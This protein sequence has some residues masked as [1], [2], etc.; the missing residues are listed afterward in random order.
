MVL[1]IL[2]GISLT[3]VALG[4]AAMF[5]AATATKQLTD[6]NSKAMNKLGQ[7][8]FTMLAGLLGVAT[9]LGLF[10]LTMHA[11]NIG[12]GEIGYAT[13]FLGGLTA[14]IVGLGMA[15]S[16]VANNQ[17][18]NLLSDEKYANMFKSIGI[19][20]ASVLIAA[21]S[22]SLINMTSAGGWSTLQNVVP[23]ILTLG[24]V[25]GAVAGILGI[26]N[27]KLIN[28]NSL[29]KLPAMLISVAVVTGAM[30][31][32][33]GAIVLLNRFAPENI[34]ESFG[35]LAALAGLLLGMTALF[36][37]ISMIPFNPLQLSALITNMIPPVILVGALAGVVILLKFHSIQLK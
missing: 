30:L 27:T 37:V 29:S 21:A 3:V 24:A 7:V 20:I 31:V 32:L 18:V 9:V 13:A 26:A 17:K 22:I 15:V 1:S 11:F 33:A 12:P 10:I 34:W 36:A 4:A 14:L 25:I 28:V 8:I 5:I 23:L 35:V 6:T 19:V 2:A 16:E